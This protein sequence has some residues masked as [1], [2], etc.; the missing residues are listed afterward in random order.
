MPSR[1]GLQEELTGDT[2]RELAPFNHFRPV[3]WSL[4]NPPTKLSTTFLCA[5]MCCCLQAKLEKLAVFLVGAGALG[6]EF[7]KNLALMGVATSA[8]HNL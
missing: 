6:C 1:G 7:L 3:A 8:L 5:H 4:S 2:S